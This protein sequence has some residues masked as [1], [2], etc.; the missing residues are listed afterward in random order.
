MLANDAAGIL[1]GGSGFG[2]EARRVGREPDGQPRV[3][4]NLVT[5]EVGDGNLGGGNEPV[6]VILELAAGDGFGVGIPA[7]EEV[8]GKFG[9]LASAEEGLAVNHERRQHFGI[10][11]FGRVQVKHEADQRPFEPC[12]SAHVDREPRATQL[13]CAFQVENAE[14][15]AQFPMRLGL[16][17]EFRNF[18]PGLHCEVVGLGLANRHF[19]MGEVGYARERLP[20]LL[21]ER[22]GDLVQFVQLFFEGAGLVHDRRGVLAGFFQCADLLAQLVAASLEALGRG[23]GLAPALIEGAKIAQQRC[24]ILPTRAQFLFNK[25]QVGT[26]KSQVEHRSTSLTDWDEGRLLGIGGSQSEPPQGAFCLLFAVNFFTVHCLLSTVY[27]PLLTD[28]APR[29]YSRLRSCRWRPGP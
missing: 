22:D 25:F 5:I 12:S 28:V 21:V 13:G 19:V 20:Q 11:V 9:Q 2:A 15:L 17:V 27:C 10:A 3:V 4:Q 24:R 6:V 26:D 7:A 14:R 16:E 29:Q 8:F 1:A 18:A 23:D